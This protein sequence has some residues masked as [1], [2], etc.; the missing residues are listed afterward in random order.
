MEALCSQCSSLATRS[1]LSSKCPTSAWVTP[2]G[3]LRRHRHQ[4]R[5]RLRN[6]RLEGSRRQRQPIAIRQNTGIANRRQRVNHLPIATSDLFQSLTRMP[7]LSPRSSSA[8]GA[9]GLRFAQAIR[10]RRLAAVVADLR[11]AGFQRSGSAAGRAADRPLQP[12][13]SPQ[14]CTTVIHSIET[15]VSYSP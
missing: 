7:G 8:G 4:R 12:V 10:R 15:T 14:F 6:P 5:T 9:Q 3:N 13:V 11:Q 2:F 1:P